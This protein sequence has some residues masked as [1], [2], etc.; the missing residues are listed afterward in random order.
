MDFV[1]PSLRCVVRDSNSYKEVQRTITT[2]P[3]MFDGERGVSRTDVDHSLSVL[4]QALSTVHG[5]PPISV[6][7]AVPITSRGVY[8]NP[9]PFSMAS[10]QLYDSFKQNGI[11]SLVPQWL[12]SG[13]AIL[14]RDQEAT[15]MR[16][17]FVYPTGDF[18]ADWSKNVSEN[19][20]YYPASKTIQVDLAKFTFQ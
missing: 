3:A 14:V 16:G 12:G 19:G 9:Y 20:L 10:R 18:P 13:L 8:G 11:N 7:C 2:L 1:L 5:G 17:M 6:A 4:T 15:G